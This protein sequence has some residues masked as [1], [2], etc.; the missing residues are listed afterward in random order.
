MNPEIRNKTPSPKR[1][2]LPEAAK[3]YR[4]KKGG[5]SP[6][7]GGRPKTAHISEALRAVLESGKAEQLASELVALAKGRKRGSAVQI[8]AL[9]E[10]ADRTEGKP[11]QA[12]ELDV[13]AHASLVERL[14]QGRLRLAKWAK[15][16]SGS[17]GHGSAWYCPRAARAVFSGCHVSTLARMCALTLAMILLMLEGQLFPAYP[18]HSPPEE[19]AN[20]QGFVLGTKNP[21]ILAFVVLVLA[22]WGQ[23]RKEGAAPVGF[24]APV[25]RFSV[26]SVPHGYRLGNNSLDF[27]IR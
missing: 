4:W 13:N 1:R 8:A 9:R 16:K 21:M 17:G 7:P 24:L 10:I 12:V 11:R 14:M 5:P 26:G 2:T 6:N 15:K 20:Y 22:K 27:L 18:V 3:P 19:S 23:M 25:S